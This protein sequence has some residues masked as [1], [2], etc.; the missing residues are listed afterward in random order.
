MSQADAFFSGEGDAWFKR[1]KDKLG[2]RDPVCDLLKHIPDIK[3]KN[4]LEVGCANGWRL[5]KLKEMYG[6][7][8]SGLEPSREAIINA[9]CENI[10]R[11]KATHLPWLSESFDMVIYGFCLYLTDP[12]DWF[13]MVEEGDNVLKDGGYLVIYDFADVSPPYRRQYE[14]N[15]DLFAYHV[16]FAKLWL[17]HPWYQL[18]NEAISEHGD[19]VTILMKTP[20][21]IPV[22]P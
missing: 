3:P 8:I 17:V 12:R 7:K 10:I 20:R 6:C 4:V 1:N 5:K 9:Q 13:L 14:H 15:K 11:G 22:R 16:D 19:K 21:A 18:Y 2:Q